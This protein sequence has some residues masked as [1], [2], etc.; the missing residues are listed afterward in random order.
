MWEYRHRTTRK[1]VFAVSIKVK[2]TDSHKFGLNSIFWRQNRLLFLMARLTRA[3]AHVFD[4]EDVNKFCAPKPQ[5][6]TLPNGLYMIYRKEEG[7][8]STWSLGERNTGDIY[9]S[10]R[11]PFIFKFRKVDESLKGDFTFYIRIKKKEFDY[12]S[13]ESYLIFRNNGS[14]YLSRW[15]NFTVFK[16]KIIFGN[17]ESLILI[18]CTRQEKHPINL[19]KVQM[20]MWNVQ[21]SSNFYSAIIE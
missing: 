2:K 7:L 17:H 10:L 12:S 19:K 15:I 20:T 11:N 18:P 4:A 13:N 6:R 5:V 8:Y 9:F 14:I 16:T 21:P 3:R 1:E